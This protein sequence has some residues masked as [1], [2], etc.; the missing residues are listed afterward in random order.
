MICHCL[1]V[2][3]CHHRSVN[4]KLNL[5]HERYLRIVYSDSGTS[6]E[7]LLNNDTTVPIHI[8][9]V[10]SL[11]IEMLKISKNGSVP[12]VNEI[13]EKQ[14]NA[15]NLRKPLEFLRRK[16]HSVFHGQVSILYLGPKIW[17]TIPVEIKN[18]TT[19]STFK[20]EV[21]K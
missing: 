21:K 6:F 17:G 1:I 8:K 15:Y 9:N 12:I 14:N 11:S 19:T 18:L 20:R 7:H 10:Q 5:L 3:V 16:I 4:N 2:W 13:F